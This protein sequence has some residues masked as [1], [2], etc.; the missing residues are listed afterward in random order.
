MAETVEFLNAERIEML[1]DGAIVVNTAR[2]NLVDD[3]A[4]IAVLRSGRLAAA[5]LD[6]FDNEANLNPGYLD[7][8]NVFMLPRAGSATHERRTAMGATCLAN[9]AALFADRTCP[10]PS[11]D[12]ELPL[13]ACSGSADT[14][15]GTKLPANRVV[16]GAPNRE[17][18]LPGSKAPHRRDDP[19]SEKILLNQYV[20]GTSDFP[21]RLLKN[22]KN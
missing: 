10:K 21:S 13:Q 1:P 16:A 8:E 6:V 12:Q 5:G 20:I 17:I 4:L 7:L 19:C 3:E 22:P 18:G 14:R 2:G 11:T 15:L 9:L